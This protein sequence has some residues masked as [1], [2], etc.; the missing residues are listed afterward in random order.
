MK[1]ILCLI[2]SVIAIC[3]FSLGA[4]CANDEEGGGG[5]NHVCSYTIVKYNAEKHWK[6]CSCGNANYI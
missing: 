2:L 5:D 3:C 6:E 1:K 4:A